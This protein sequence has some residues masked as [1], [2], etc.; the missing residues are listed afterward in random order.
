M[1]KSPL[2]AL[3]LGIGLSLAPI[4]ACAAG[5]YTGTAPVATQSDQDRAA[6]LR[7]ALSQAVTQA[8]KGD[9][10]VLKRPEVARALTRAERYTRQYSYQ[11]NSTPV[12]PGKPPAKFLLV[13]QFDG[14]QIDA[15]V[16]DQGLAA[17]PAAAASPAG[18]NTP[19]P[20]PAASPAAPPAAAASANV[21]AAAPQADAAPAPA[22]AGSYRVWFSGLRSADDYARLVGALNGSPEVRALRVE[23]A[24]GNVLQARIDARGSLQELTESLDAAR[25]A[26]ATNTKPPVE[27]VDAVLDLEP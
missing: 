27:G 14:A 11:P 22:A 12:E 2:K 6:A 23:Q 17:A 7:V 24:H 8:A 1:P 18:T 19:N 5:I 26:R 4:F 16:R 25:I 13:A 21:E 9:A 15:L 20:P 10:A 3:I